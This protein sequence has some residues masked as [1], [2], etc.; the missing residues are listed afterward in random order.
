MHVQW[1]GF[2]HTHT[3]THTHQAITRL[4]QTAKN[5]FLHQS[6]Q[7]LTTVCYHLKSVSKHQFTPDRLRSISQEPIRLSDPMGVNQVVET[8]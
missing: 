5:Q 2:H 6:G 7:R 4:E 3:H 1:E 8:V